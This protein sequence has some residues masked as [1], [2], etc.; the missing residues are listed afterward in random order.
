M[1]ANAVTMP[2]ASSH[3]IVHNLTSSELKDVKGDLCH[4]SCQRCDLTI[5]SSLRDSM[6][7]QARISVR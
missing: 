2:K 5:V 4:S 7:A 3:Y 6:T 1:V